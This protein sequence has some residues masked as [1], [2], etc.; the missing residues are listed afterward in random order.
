MAMRA[1][2]EDFAFANMTCGVVGTGYG[3]AA[4]MQWLPVASSIAESVVDS[5]FD[6]I[7]LMENLPSAWSSGTVKGTVSYTHLIR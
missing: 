4:V 1:G 5:R 7:N 6:Q 3:H 2:F